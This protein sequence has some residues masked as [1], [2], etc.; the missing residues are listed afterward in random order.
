MSRGRLPS[1]LIYEVAFRIKRPK[2]K[3]LRVNFAKSWKSIDSFE[4]VELIWSYEES[5]YETHH[6]FVQNEESHLFT[7]AEVAEELMKS[8]NTSVSLESLV[9]FLKRK[10]IKNEDVKD[11]GID[12]LEL[13]K[14]NSVKCSEHKTRTRKEIFRDRWRA[15]NYG[16]AK[17]SYLLGSTMT[18]PV[19][20]PEASTRRINQVSKQKK[21]AKP[22][23]VP[24]DPLP[25]PPPPQ[26]KKE[27]GIV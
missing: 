12:V 4:G 13:Y 2:V 7:P 8:D 21:V 24:A 26:E 25:P 3:K 23:S 27:L 5:R 10:R 6:D 15:K 1:F 14:M 19:L 22:P 17:G 18:D 11:D 9:K 16:L 20:G